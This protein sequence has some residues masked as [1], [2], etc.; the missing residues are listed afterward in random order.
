MHAPVLVLSKPLSILNPFQGFSL[1]SPSS[2]VCLKAR[3]FYMDASCEI[4]LWYLMLDDQEVWCLGF[5]ALGVRNSSICRIKM[6]FF[7]GFRMSMIKF[8]DLILNS[9]FSL[10]KI[11]MH[12][13]WQVLGLA[14]LWLATLR[15]LILIW[16][17]KNKNFCYILWSY[18]FE[19]FV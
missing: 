11:W 9:S 14:K 10:G 18:F 2:F 16:N 13:W 12:R 15:F 1:S 4:D 8:S 3:V 6:T 17:E 5:R 19:R 7:F